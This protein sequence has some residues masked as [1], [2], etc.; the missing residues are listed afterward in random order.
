MSTSIIE[1]EYIIVGLC[2]SQ[3]LRIKQMLSD[4]GI[5]IRNFILLY[6]NTSVICISKNSIQNLRT[7]HIDIKLQFIRDLT[8]L[9]IFSLHHIDTNIQ[10]VDIFSKSLDFLKFKSLRKVIR[11]CISP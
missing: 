9:N 4:Y 1:T 6:D 10:L 11:V 5:I 7:K 2:Y 3:L 8:E